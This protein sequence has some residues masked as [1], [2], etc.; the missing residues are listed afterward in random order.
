MSARSAATKYVR[1]RVG[2]LSSLSSESQATLEGGGMK[3]KAPPSSF[4]L[5]PLHKSTR[6]LGW[7]CQTRQAQRSKSVGEPAHRRGAGSGAGAG[8]GGGVRAGGEGC[9]QG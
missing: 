6:S 2:S 3:D 5:H 4:H 7:S 1:K 8:P 9:V